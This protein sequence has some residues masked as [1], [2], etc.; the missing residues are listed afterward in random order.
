MLRCVVLFYLML[1][2]VV[3]S[4]HI[5]SCLALP[6]KVAIVGGTHGN[7]ANGVY[8]VSH[9]TRNPSLV[10][11]ESFETTTLLAN[12]DAIGA[13]VRYVGKF[14]KRQNKTRQIMSVRRSMTKIKKIKGNARSKAR[15]D[16]GEDK[17]EGKDEDK[18]RA[19]T[20]Q[21]KDKTKRR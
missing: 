4:R 19:S 13:N 12:T 9:F 15:H 21:G 14:A 10:Y 2:F 5:L 18:T 3:F 7:E 11:R 20:R 17:D 16:K 1:C 8:L 6:Y